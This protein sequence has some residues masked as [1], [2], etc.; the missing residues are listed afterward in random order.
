MH[1]KNYCL[2]SRKYKH[3]Y[4]SREK[5]SSFIA[6]YSEIIKEEKG[7]APVRSYY[8]YECGGFHVTS[9]Q[10]TRSQE[11]QLLA[12]G[13][14]VDEPKRRKRFKH[15]TYSDMA[16]D[17]ARRYNK[18][19]FDKVES[20]LSEVTLLLQNGM[21]QTARKMLQDVEK[22]VGMVLAADG[23]KDRKRAIKQDRE[24]LREQLSDKMAA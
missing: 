14:E 13:V 7:Y 17:T 20:E 11:Q 23:P 8:C 10:Y 15:K 5:A 16:D 21:R 24:W 2:L 4:P 18:A 6:N 12:Q 3:L 19:S 9:R 22:H 1:H